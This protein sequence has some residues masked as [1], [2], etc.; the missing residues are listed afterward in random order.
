MLR[1]WRNPEFVRHRRSELRQTRALTVVVV[2]IVICI[3]LG[4][5]C[6][7]SRQNALEAARRAAEYFDGHWSSQLAEMEQRKYIDFWQLFF[8]ALML[9][10][11]EVLTFW[12][13]L[14]CAQSISGERDRKTWD[15]QRITRLS[16]SELLVGKVLGEPVLAYFI[17]LC[18]LPIAIVAGVAGRVRLVDIASAY[19]L[20]LASALFIGLAGTWLSSLLR[21]EAA[22]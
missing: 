20:I 8:R 16:P 14:S 11:A 10:Q 13:L 21:V 9:V 7:I 15:F 6:W 19:A 1:F 2:V 3:L 4:L 18:C 17:V 5:A 12:S 22:A